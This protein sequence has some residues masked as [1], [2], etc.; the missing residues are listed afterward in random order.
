MGEEGEFVDAVEQEIAAEI[1]EEA[2]TSI[3]GQ[4]AD[5]DILAPATTV[6][7]YEEMLAEDG[8]NTDCLADEAS[9]EEAIEDLELE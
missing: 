9:Y 2:E 8:E 6:G 1:A 5:F 7:E 4:K 3:W